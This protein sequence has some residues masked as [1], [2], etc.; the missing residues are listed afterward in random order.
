M[1]HTAIISI[2]KNMPDHSLTPIDIVLDLENNH[3]AMLDVCNFIGTNALEAAID[4]IDSRPRRPLAAVSTGVLM[5]PSSCEYASIVIEYIK[6][7][8][9]PMDTNIGLCK[10]LVVANRRCQFIVKLSHDVYSF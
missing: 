6:H 8:I 10:G 9:P 1:L 7:I 2:R 4:M 5:S 3:L